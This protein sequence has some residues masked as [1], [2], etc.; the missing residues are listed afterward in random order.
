VTVDRAGIATLY[1]KDESQNPTWS[2]KVRWTS[3][4]VSKG[5]ELGAETVTIASTGNHGAS[6]AAYAGR[7]GLD[8]VV[9]TIP[10]VP[11]TMKTLMQVYGAAVVVLE[12]QLNWELRKTLR[13]FAGAI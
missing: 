12:T 1:V 10:A 7:G 4:A 11:E 5:V 3:V 2:F 8:C 6:T 9:F 13:N